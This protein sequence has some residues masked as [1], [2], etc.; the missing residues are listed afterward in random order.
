LFRKYYNKWCVSLEE[1]F[2]WIRIPSAVK[3]AQVKVMVRLVKKQAGSNY[4]EATLK[5]GGDWGP[6]QVF[7]VVYYK[8]IIDV[9]DQFV[10]V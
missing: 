1:N 5:A 2:T 9:D 4:K 8:E 3:N 6:N 10:E 7:C